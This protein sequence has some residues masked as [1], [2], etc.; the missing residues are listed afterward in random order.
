[1]L[2]TKDTVDF[3]YTCDT[4]LSD[5]GF[6]SLVAPDVKKVSEEEIARVKAEWEEAQK[7]KKEKAK[8]KEKEKEKDKDKDD[9]D[10]SKGK[11]KEKSP[12]DD[13]K[14]P[15]AISPAPSTP[16]HQKYALHRDYFAMRQDVHRKRRQTA[17]AKEVAPRLPS[18]PHVGMPGS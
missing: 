12:D 13:P 10:K 7:R 6:A 2:A 1:M 14:M 8:E 11:E 5:P 15:G 17:Q 3:L 18:A 16:T 9:K 4:H